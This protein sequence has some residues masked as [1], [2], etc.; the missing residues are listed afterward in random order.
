MQWQKHHLYVECISGNK[1]ADAAAK[2]VVNK[3][4]FKITI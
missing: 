4:V 2:G 1:K 3:N